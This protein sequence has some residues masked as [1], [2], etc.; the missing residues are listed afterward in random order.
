M[1]IGDPALADLTLYGIQFNLSSPA[2]PAIPANAAKSS[3]GTTLFSQVANGSSSVQLSSNM[4]IAT[5]NNA[6]TSVQ[7]GDMTTNST[8][9]I[10]VAGRVRP[11]FDLMLM[12]VLAVTQCS[13]H[14]RPHAHVGAGCVSWYRILSCCMPG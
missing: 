1:Q 13:M 14:V 5:S 10:S 7:M 9:T 3:Y 2:L 6:D 11:I 4:P 8:V 12:N